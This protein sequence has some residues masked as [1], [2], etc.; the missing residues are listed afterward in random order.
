MAPLSEAIR[1]EVKETLK[2]GTQLYECVSDPQWTSGVV[3][4]GGYSIGL[5]LDAAK[6]CQASSTHP[7]V[8]H[9]SS[10]F[11][12]AAT[13]GLMQIKI[14]E[15]KT[16][17]RFTNLAAELYQ[18]NILKATFQLIFGNFDQLSS[19]TMTGVSIPRTHAPLHP[20]VVHPAEAKLTP[21]YG[22][23]NYAMHFSWARDAYFD[24]KNG[25]LGT[26]GRSVDGLLAGA[27]FRLHESPEVKLS[28]AYIPF[29]VDSIES[30]WDK[31]TE[32]HTQGRQF[33]HPS[34][35]ITIGFKCRFPLSS[36][37]ASH[38]LGVFGWKR[39]LTDGLWSDSTEIWSAPS[40][41]GD[42]A[43]MD[44]KWRENMVCVAVASQFAYMASYD[45]NRRYLG[46]DESKL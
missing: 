20:L 25:R 14:S 19:S 30:P 35:S 26:E 18:K 3:T 32:E 4:F 24:D 23:Q 31:L 11:L 41:L 21:H 6:R 17:S 27:W 36:D 1:T 9:L 12:R 33:W 16:G 42:P 38:T 43:E 39:H 46:G 10:Q 40:E 22:S 7:D 29:F 37:Y 15:L 2:D 13:P 44:S 5:V 34:L 8:V 45:I 28:P